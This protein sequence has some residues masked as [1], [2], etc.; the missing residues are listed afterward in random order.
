MKDANMA[1]MRKER[2]QL[3]DGRYLIYYSFSDDPP[4]GEDDNKQPQVN[5]GE[6]EA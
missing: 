5:A 1:S 6:D 3:A 4:K 2:V